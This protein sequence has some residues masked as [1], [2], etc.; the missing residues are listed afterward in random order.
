MSMLKHMAYLEDRE[1]KGTTKGCARTFL[2]HDWEWGAGLVGV[3]VSKGIFDVHF[4]V[5][6]ESGLDGLSGWW[7]SLGHLGGI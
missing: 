2:R 7:Y 5:I 4:E 6:G 1:G 3:C